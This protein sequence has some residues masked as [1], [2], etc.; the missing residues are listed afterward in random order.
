MLRIEEGGGVGEPHHGLRVARGFLLIVADCC[1]DREKFK[2]WGC[3]LRSR[4]V[5]LVVEPARLVSAFLKSR[6]RLLHA[7]AARESVADGSGEEVG[8]AERIADAEREPGVLVKTRVA[9]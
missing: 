1:A 6:Q 8:V 7:E 9:D 3:E 2:W 4:D 5:L